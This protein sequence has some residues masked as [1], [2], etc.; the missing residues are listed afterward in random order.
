VSCFQINVP[1][2]KN[3]RNVKVMK[4]HSLSKRE[5]SKMPEEDKINPVMTIILLTGM[6]RPSFCA[7]GQDITD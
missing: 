2:K 6:D 3:E 7:L 4:S 1:K 5:M